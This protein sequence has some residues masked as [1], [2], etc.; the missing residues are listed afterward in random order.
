VVDQG[1]FQMLHRGLLQ[2][3]LASLVEEGQIGRCGG[4]LGV[5]V[6]QMSHCLKVAERQTQLLV[7]DF[8][9]HLADKAQRRVSEG[10]TV[11]HKIR[12]HVI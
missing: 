8:L 2:L 7:G 4:F 6:T 12:E 5:L 11:D 3:W 9:R 10:P 1:F